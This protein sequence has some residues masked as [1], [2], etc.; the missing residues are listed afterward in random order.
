MASLSHSQKA[1][2]LPVALAGL[3]LWFPALALVGL[4]LAWLLGWLQTSADVYLQGFATDRKILYLIPA[5]VIVLVFFGRHPFPPDD[6][7]RDMTAWAY[8][9]DYRQMFWGSPR[10]PL[11]DNYIGFD[12]LA[13]FV[14]RHFPHLYAPLLFQGAALLGF[15]VILPAILSRKLAA[16]PLRWTWIALA[17]AAL[18]YTPVLDRIVEARPEVFF[19]LWALSAFLVDGAWFWLWLGVGLLLTPTYWLAGAY[20]AAF[21]VLPNRSWRFRWGGAILFGLA[22]VGIWMALTHGTWWH[23][24]IGLSTVIQHRVYGITEDEGLAVLLQIPVI[25][26]GLLSFMLLPWNWRKTRTGTWLLL[27]WFCIP[28]MMRYVDMLAPLG[29]ILLAEGWNTETIQKISPHLLK[30]IRMASFLLLF[31]L[32]WGMIPPNAPSF[33]HVPGVNGTPATDIKV[34]SP[35]GMQTY[36]TLYANP[37]VRI[38]PAMDPGMT[39][40][41]LQRIAQAPNQSTCAQL[42]A[43]GADYYLT[44]QLRGLKPCLHLTDISGSWQLWKIRQPKGKN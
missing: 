10:V 17:M 18:L 30:K 41:S 42:Q 14:Y 1:I 12:Y 38:A 31:A 43:S 6:L 4:G 11:F 32:P 29:F 13:G 27:L 24:F 8:H 3:A 26:L 28:W 5:A 7:L 20:A 23:S 19:A 25:S 22:T 16:D 35:F 33:L 34:L 21:F 37:G 2:L 15:L 44:N 40:R 9:Y 39:H 36:A